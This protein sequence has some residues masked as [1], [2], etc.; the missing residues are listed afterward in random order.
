[1]VIVH[2]MSLDRFFVRYGMFV[3]HATCCC[4]SLLV[5]YYAD[6]SAI[7]SLGNS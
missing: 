6:V 4:R 1:M 5:G 7:M 2:A 3:E